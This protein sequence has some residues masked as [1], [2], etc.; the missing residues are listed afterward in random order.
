MKNTKDC[1]KLRKNQ[2]GEIF[3]IEGNNAGTCT[4]CMEPCSD[5]E[6]ELPK[7]FMTNEEEEGICNA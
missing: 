2:I 4:R 6:T 3:C 7:H 5:S 1:P